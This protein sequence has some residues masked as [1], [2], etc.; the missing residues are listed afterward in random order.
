MIGKTVDPYTGAAIVIGAVATAT[1][2]IVGA[3]KSWKTRSETRSPNGTRTGVL[4][5]QIKEG[6]DRNI[7]DVSRLQRVIFDHISKPAE[8]GH[9]GKRYDDPVPP[10]LEKEG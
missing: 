3:V 6:L 1:A 2:S 4:V 10:P 8:T 9:I 5:H 7:E